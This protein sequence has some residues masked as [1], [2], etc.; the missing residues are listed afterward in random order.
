MVGVTA[1]PGRCWSLVNGPLAG[2]RSTIMRDMQAESDTAAPTMPGDVV[3]AR[4]QAKFAVAIAVLALV[5]AP[6]TAL[7]AAHM[8]D[9]PGP[10]GPAG[11]VGSTGPVGPPGPQGQ[12][13]PS[14][15]PGPA[16]AVQP[17]TAMP[18]G[19]EV[20]STV[21][22]WGDR[23]PAGTRPWQTVYAAAE[24]PL[25]VPGNVSRWYPLEVCRPL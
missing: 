4:H 25:G 20:T 23:C 5:A 12:R 16:G 15:P 17:T 1:A 22:A 14:G 8:A 9:S 2:P 10:A 21:V 13:G 18:R 24:D 11:A 3:Q 6:V 7:V 19:A